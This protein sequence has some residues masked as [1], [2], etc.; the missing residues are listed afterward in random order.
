MY[1]VMLVISRTRSFS[2]TN[3][4]WLLIF[5]MLCSL[6][7]YFNE[8]LDTV[9]KVI[10]PIVIVCTSF[11]FIKSKEVLLFCSKRKS[12]ILSWFSGMLCV[13]TCS[14]YI[15]GYN[16]AYFAVLTLLA[17]ITGLSVVLAVL[18]LREDM[19]RST[20]IIDKLSSL[21][22]EVY[23][24]HL[25]L[26]ALIYHYVETPVIQLLLICISSLL[27]SYILRYIAEKCTRL[28]FK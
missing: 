19:L 7:L 14:L 6:V 3:S 18:S 8:S 1:F 22:Y 20:P 5:T 26:A 2:I 11:L 12:K 25:P 9:S 24:V 23:L 15:M 21:S 16:D 28:F 17:S 27:V 13:A 4:I 10:P